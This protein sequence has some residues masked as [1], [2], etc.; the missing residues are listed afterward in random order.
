MHV[1]IYRYVMPGEILDVSEA[2]K[3]LLEIDIQSRVSPNTFVEANEFRAA[4]CYTEE[5]TGALTHHRKSLRNLF[6]GLSGGEGDSG[7]DGETLSLQEWK[8]FMRGI[9]L[10][11][12]DITD[13][14]ATLCFAWSRMVVVE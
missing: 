9:G 4:F 10:I 6:D 12:I 2:L 7:L 11:S 13:R 1:A 14:E 5:C 3:Q 8:A